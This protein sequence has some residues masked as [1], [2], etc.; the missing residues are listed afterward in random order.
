MMYFNVVYLLMPD[1]YTDA[2]SVNLKLLLDS[3]EVNHLS[4]ALN[5]VRWDLPIY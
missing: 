5:N 3:K 4:I 1:Q 2:T